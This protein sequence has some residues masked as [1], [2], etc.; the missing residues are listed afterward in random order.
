M[1]LSAGPVL[2]KWVTTR[3]VLAV[4][5]TLE[6]AII[7]MV[8]A[9][10]R[11]SRRA[12]RARMAALGTGG[13]WLDHPAKPVEHPPIVEAAGAEIRADALVIGVEIGG[14]ARAYRLGALDDPGGH[15][16]NDIISGMPVTVAYCNLSQNAQIYMNTA[17]GQPLDV[18]VVGLRDHQMVIR[19]AGSLYFHP[20]GLP[21]EPEKKPPPLPCGVLTPMVTTWKAWTNLHPRTDVYLGDG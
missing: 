21:V 17:G 6:A 11:A 18:E 9:G 14:K 10:E 8:V 15:L 5:L 7:G 1:I 13:L 2:R 12:D 16:V 19:V 20:S 3:N 4:L